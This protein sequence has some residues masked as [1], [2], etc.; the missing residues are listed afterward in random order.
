M[1]NVIDRPPQRGIGRFL[2]ALA[3]VVALGWTSTAFPQ[4]FVEHLSP[5]V[6]QRGA[7]T[8]IEVL[9]S[10][11]AGA[12]GLW[13]SLPTEVFRVRPVINN[14]NSSTSAAFDVE[15]TREAPLG[16]YGLRLATRSGL[17]NVHLF[18]VDELPAIRDK[19]VREMYGDEFIDELEHKY[20]H[21]VGTALTDRI[22]NGDEQ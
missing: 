20:G 9:G 8:R 13:S 19:V 7:T 3:I 6:L 5:P 14:E 16:L 1:P 4:A 10:D 2:S 18:L 11:T 22:D 15:L 21:L 17:S 12:I